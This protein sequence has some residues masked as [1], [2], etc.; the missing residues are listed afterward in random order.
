[1]PSPIPGCHLIGASASMAAGVAACL[2]FCG[3]MGTVTNV[4]V[5]NP[6]ESAVCS[7]FNAC[8]GAICPL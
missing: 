5:P 6:G 7:N 4:I 1:M 8:S 3:G 2:Q